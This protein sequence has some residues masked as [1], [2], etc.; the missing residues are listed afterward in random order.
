MSRF[1][2]A[3]AAIRILV[4]AASI[5]LIYA[6]QGVVGMKISI[7]APATHT[8]VIAGMKY[9][10]E[11]LTVK[12]GDIVVWVNKDFFPHTGPELDRWRSHNL[13]KRRSGSPPHI[14]C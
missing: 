14:P 10:P 5:S 11:T 1:S 9:S 7:A 13:V 2:P 8:I 3:K 12:R 4:A 6:L